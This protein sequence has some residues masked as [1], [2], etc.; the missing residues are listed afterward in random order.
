MTLDPSKNPL[1]LAPVAMRLAGQDLALIV[2]P[3]A[4]RVAFKLLGDKDPRVMLI[5][6]RCDAVIL[7]CAACALIATLDDKADVSRVEKWLAAEPRK[8]KELEAATVEAFAR[9]YR[10]LG[11]ADDDDAPPGGSGA[12]PSSPSTSGA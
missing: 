4:A 9:Y 3:K 6:N 11:I 10:A 12:P 2:T 7:S 5:V 8:Y 1:G